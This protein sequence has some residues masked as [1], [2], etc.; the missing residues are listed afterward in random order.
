[1][2]Q[3]YLGLDTK[4]GDVYRFLA[5]ARSFVDKTSGEASSGLVLNEEPNSLGLE[6]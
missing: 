2:W 4:L 5:F 1:M 6:A 3:Q